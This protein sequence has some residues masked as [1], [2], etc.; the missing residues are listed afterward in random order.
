MHLWVTNSTNREL[1]ATIYLECKDATA[2]PHGIPLIIKR[3]YTWQMITA[4]AERERK[5]ERESLAEGM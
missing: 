1:N 2:N 5:R 3:V 4:P